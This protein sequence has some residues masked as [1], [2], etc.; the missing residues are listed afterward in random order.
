MGRPSA[1]PKNHELL[2]N[3]V[4]K[5]DEITDLS[6]AQAEARKNS[7]IDEATKLDERLDL[8]YA[9]KERRVGAW[10]QH[11]REHGC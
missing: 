6:R 2:K 1:C 7:D 11:V 8:V 9:E 4:A 5:L 10:Q 3:V